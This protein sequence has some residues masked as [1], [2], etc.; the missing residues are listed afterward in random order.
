MEAGQ[1]TTIENTLASTVSLTREAG[2]RSVLQAYEE[3]RRSRGDPIVLPCYRVEQRG[4]PHG[5]GER[6]RAQARD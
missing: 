5:V 1:R 4:L 6:R 3:V 2:V